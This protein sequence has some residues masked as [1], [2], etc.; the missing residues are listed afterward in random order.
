MKTKITPK[1]LAQRWGIDRH[2]VLAWIRKGELRAIDASL[3]QG[4]RPRFLIDEKDIADFE[5]RRAVVP[6][7]PPMRRRRDDDDIPNYI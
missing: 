5:L 3:T 6:S 4:G 2:T 1:E 7:P